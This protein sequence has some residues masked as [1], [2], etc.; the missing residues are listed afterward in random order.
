MLVTLL[1]PHQVLQVPQFEIIRVLH[2]F[3]T[4]QALII[5]RAVGAFSIFLMRQYTVGIPN[6]LLDAARVDGA[7]E[8]GIW[9]RVVLPLVRPALAVVGI[10]AFTGLWND[11][12]WPL[13]VTTD[14]S[15]FVANLGIASLVGPYDYQYG[16]QLSG[17]VLAALPIIIIFL[18]FQRQF[19]EGLTQGALK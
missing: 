7:S 10:L 4:Y 8:F 18:I 5:P 3:N 1:I 16:I 2:W 15:M 6:E 9:W 12:F 13:I 11:F 14:T 19:L 17:A